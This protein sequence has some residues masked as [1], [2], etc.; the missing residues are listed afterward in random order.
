MEILG[1]ILR[2]LALSQMKMQIEFRTTVFFY[3]KAAAVR[4]RG[5]V[6]PRTPK[7]FFYNLFNL[8]MNMHHV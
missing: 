4:G 7:A 5:C 2:W 1:Y 6:H 3:C 8:R